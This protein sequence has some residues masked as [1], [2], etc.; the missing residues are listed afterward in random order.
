MRSYLV[1]FFMLISMFFYTYFFG[2]Q[3]SLLMLYMLILSPVLSL[4]VALISKKNLEVVVDPKAD[5]LQIEKDDIVRVKIFVKNKSN[6][7]IPIVYIFFFNPSNLMPLSPPHLFISLGPLEARDIVLEYQAQYR[8]EAR[9]GIEKVVIKDFLGFFKFSVIENLN[10]NGRTRDIVVLNRITNLQVNSTLLLD[11]VQIV[12]EE[13]G[14]QSNNLNFM[15]YLYAEPGYE[16]REYQP[17]DPLHRIHWKLSAKSDTFMV[18]KDEGVS[19]AKKKLILDPFISGEKLA[20]QKAIQR[21]DKILEILISIINMM[22]KAG[23]EIELWLFD[24]G[25][26]TQYSI[27]DREEVIRM[28]HRLALYQFAYSNANLDRLPLQGVTAKEIRG[29]SLRGGDVMVFTASPDRQIMQYIEQIQGLNMAIAL[30]LLEDND[31]SGVMN[32][33]TRNLNLKTWA[34]GVNDDLSKVFV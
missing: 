18:R 26:W 32:Q 19:F 13:T 2:E 16:F 7:P 14:T 12:G 33:E 24:K 27:N 20:P 34:I 11:S 29:R 23:R 30:V 17:G 1:Y 8:G 3:V 31:F 10:E 9:I 15:S 5:L 22:I 4:S 6:F 25:E 28:R 21:E